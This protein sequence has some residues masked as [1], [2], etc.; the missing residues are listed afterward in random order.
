MAAEMIFKVEE[1]PE[2]DRLIMLVKGAG[3]TQKKEMQLM[4]KCLNLGIEIGKGMAQVVCE[5]A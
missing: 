1:K 3:E 2:I 5:K 4:M